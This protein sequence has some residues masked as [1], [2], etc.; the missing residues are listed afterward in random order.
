MRDA[1]L[2]VAG[3]EHKRWMNIAITSSLEA[4]ASSFNLSVIE[5]WSAND[6]PIPIRAG[7]A[8]TVKIDGETVTTG[9]VDDDPASY[10]EN[11]HTFEVSGRSVTGD[12]V[13]CSAVHATGQWT[14]KT[15]D[16]IAE[17]LCDPFGIAVTSEV[18]VGEKFPRFALQYGE[19]VFEALERLSRMRGLLMTTSPDGDLVFTK[20]GALSTTTVIEYGKNVIRGSRTGGYQGR[21]S[22][23]IVHG[24]TAGTDD[25][26]GA[27]AA[28]LKAR[29][30][31][32]DITRYRP[33][34]VQAECPSNAADVKVR[35][36][37]ERNIRAGRSRRLQYTLDGWE[38]SPGRVWRPNTL[39]RVVDPKL[40][41][42][43]ELLV[44]TVRL[45][46]GEQGTQT[47]LELGNP[48][49]MTP[50]PTFKPQP[51]RNSKHLSYL[52]G[53]RGAS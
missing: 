40:E 6:K 3:Q 49:A 44:I 8:C 39:V 51:K 50:E 31:D 45:S 9:F 1:V 16:A 26:Y 52:D 36:N 24:Q 42:D 18:D 25:T 29:V 4:L 48:Q 37:W 17:E 19:T 47:E 27:A 30:T 34:I 46:K 2:E 53:T 5:S 43:T 33:L 35:A 11:D 23:Y 12:L 21:H 22:E 10:D 14:N 32:D 20:V 7:D 28:H 41:V 15:I 13:D 38:E